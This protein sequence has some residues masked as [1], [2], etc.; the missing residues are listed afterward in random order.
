MRLSNLTLGTPPSGIREVFNR[1][2]EVENV[3]SF[4]LGEP[5]YHTPG[6]FLEAAKR[7]MDMGRT[8]YTPNAGIMDLRTAVAES[9]GTRGI[10]PEQ[11]VV[12]AGATEALLLVFMTLLNC[13]EEVIVTE[14][15][16]PTYLGQI[17]AVGGVVNFVRTYEEDG[18]VPRKENIEK[19]I[20]GKTRMIILNSPA[21]PTGALMSGDDLMGI[22]E[23]AREHDL[24]VISDEVYKH[25]VFD[26]KRFHSIY[27]FPGMKERCLIV[28]S[29]SKA[30]AMTGWRIGYIVAPPDVAKALETMHEYGVSCISEPIQRAAVEALRH[31]GDFV[32]EMRQS[33]EKRRNMIVEGIS[34]IRGLR[35]LTPP[36]TFYLYFNIEETGMNSKDF[37]NKLLDEQKIALAPGTA[38]GEGQEHYIRLSYA[39]SEEKLKTAIDRI[40]TFIQNNT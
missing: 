24:I 29:F 10:L 8:H 6:Q 17:R 9:Y 21:N 34:G 26:D 37:V 13:G 14:P 27:D 15:Y 5:D 39:N 25:I 28:D 31:G 36:A 33:Y 2:A 40:D 12:T 7:S 18:F 22:A 1:V 4:A 16:W 20:T 11:V 32:K 23:L 38:F 19:A 3:I 35:C 30:Y